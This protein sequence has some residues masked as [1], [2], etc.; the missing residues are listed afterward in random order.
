MYVTGNVSDVVH[1]Y[2][3][4]SGFDLSTVSYD[5][6]SFDVGSQESSPQGLIFNTDGTR[7]FVVGSSSDTVYQY[8][9][10]TGFDVSTA[11]YDSI[12]FSVLSQ[13]SVPRG[14]TFNTDGT[15]MFVIGSSSDSVY[16]Y[17][18]EKIFFESEDVG[19][20]IIGNGGDVILTSTDGSYIVNTNF[21]D[22]SE[23]A[24]EDWQLVGLD[25]VSAAGGLTTSGF[26]QAFDL[27]N[28]SY[29]S[30][31]FSVSSQDSI[32]KGLAF[33]T[34]GTKM[35]MI[36]SSSD[37]VHQ[38]SLSTAFDVSS[39]SY[40]SVSFDV[41]SQDSIPEGLA[42]NTD[43]TKMFVIGDAQNTV[44]QYTLSTGF[45]LSTASNTIN[46]IN[47]SSEDG[48]ATGLAFSTDGTKMFVIG[49]NSD[50]V[51]QYTLPAAFDLS[52]TTSY[53]NVSFSVSS[54]ET[55]PEGLAFNTDGT[56]MYMIGSPSDTV[57]Q[58]TLTTGFDLSTASYDN[59]SFSVSS[60]EGAP[61]G[62]AFSTDGTKMY[63]I[64]YFSDSV[65]Q[66]STNVIF[67]HTDQYTTA[68]TKSSTNTTNWTD[69]NSMTADDS[70]NDNEVYYAISNDDRQTWYVVKD[71]RGER[72]IVRNNAGTW[73]MNDSG[74]YSGTSW[75][76]APTNDE[77]YALQE[78]IDSSIA[79]FT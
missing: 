9:L 79:L 65:H 55:S 56:K 35:Y 44:H 16:Q 19:K 7:M 45:D 12:S 31:S 51:Y 21:N 73:E 23:I 49:S 60:E 48:G 6:V 50:T 62:L 59:I 78:A 61:T 8:T 40:D 36:G 39:A 4:S 70:V 18:V 69:V 3:L 15:K 43:G 58:Y 32:P 13:E 1:Q 57:H 5:S 17:S 52:N 72:P 75:I 22:L 42:F 2:T 66:Y 77:Y 76:S 14:L 33:N 30:I 67:L 46:A 37:S 29:D 27:E 74:T 53:D 20:R 28:A 10:T 11:S 54:E 64:G 25:V 26:F 38:Y 41:S 63:V 68:I 24:S 34:D 47:I 71:S